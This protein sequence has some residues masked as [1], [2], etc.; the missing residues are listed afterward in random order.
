MRVSVEKDDS[1]YRKDA[2]GRNYEAYLNGKRVEKCITA[3]EEEGYIKR[4]KTDSTGTEI[5]KT[6]N[7]ERYLETEELYGNVEIKEV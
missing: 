3:D 1:G 7:G 5:I 6:E 4:F 2:T